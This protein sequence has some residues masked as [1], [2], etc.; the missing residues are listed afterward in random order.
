MGNYL[1]GT[2]FVFGVI[3]KDDGDGC[4]TL[5]LYLMPLKNIIK[6]NTVN[7]ILCIFYHILKNI[8]YR[9]QKLQLKYEK[10]LNRYFSKG[11]T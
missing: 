4:M 10:D 11:V 6:N 5:W 7:F 3:R 2:K 9:S 8:N 1:M